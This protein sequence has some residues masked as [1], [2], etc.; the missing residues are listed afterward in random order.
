MADLDDIK[1]GKDFRTD[2]P[3]QNIPFILKGCGALD[4]G[5]QSRL[6]RIFDP[7]TGKTVML[8]FDHGYF[9]GPTTGL[10]RID[11]N[12]APLFEHADVLMC[13]RGILRSVVPPA[14]NKPVVLRASGANSILAELSNEAVALSM[15]DAVRLNSCAVAAQVYIGSEYEHQSIKNIIQLVDAGMKVGMP[16]MAVTGVGKDMVRDQRYFSLATRIAAEMGAQIIKT[17]YVEKGF[18]R[19]VAGCPVPI[20]IAGGKK[21]PETS[22]CLLSWPQANVVVEGRCCYLGHSQDRQ[23]IRHFPAALWQAAPPPDAIVQRKSANIK[24][25]SSQTFFYSRQRVT[26]IVDKIDKFA[27]RHQTIEQTFFTR[28]GH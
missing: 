18:E 10:E 4:W 21:L 26:P 3:Q 7:K 22:R 19:I 14:T 24:R 15:D 27:S 5:M 9:Q 25:G 17:Y 8:A 6:S 1:D 13:T 20:V 28:P 23:H 11:I 16:T 12:I 2:Q